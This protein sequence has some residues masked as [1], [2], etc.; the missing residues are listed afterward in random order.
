MKLFLEILKI[1]GLS[2]VVGFLVYCLILST[3]FSCSALDTF[4]NESVY[5]H[6]FHILKKLLIA[7]GIW[8]SGI[9]IYFK[10]KKKKLINLLVFISLLTILSLYSF[11]IKAVSRIPD[12]NKELKQEVCRK[13]T[14]DGMWLEFNNL[15][16]IEYDFINSKN[17]YLPSVPEESD[18]I[19]IKFYRDSF[20][21]DFDLNIELKLKP[22]ESLDTIKYP[23]WYFDGKIY[24]FNDFQN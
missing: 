1:I 21:G 18:T 6:F 9:I 14:D 4:Y 2:T 15:S 11:I 24:H 22:D 23:N 12:K 8:I 3:D 19:N 20:L 10:I 16:K 7:F 5:E 13:S 17:K